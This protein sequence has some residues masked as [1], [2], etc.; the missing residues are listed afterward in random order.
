MRTTTTAHEL[1]APLGSVHAGRLVFTRGVSNLTIVV[2]ASMDELYRARFD[3]MMPEVG[4]HGGTVTVRY[5]PSLLPSR[6][7]ITLSGRVPWNITGRW[8]M[9]HVV[10][11]LEDLD[12][13][14][15]VISGGCSH[16][17]VRLPRPRRWVGVRI[18]G[19][20]HDVELV[21]PAGVPV[22]VRIGGGSSKLAIDDFRL[23]A[24]GGKTD[25]R[26]PDYDLIEARYDV[27]IGAG[28]SE[29]T[30]RT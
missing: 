18:G 27:E 29:V 7:E 9:S 15:L 14:G 8:G 30:V 24:G 4:V 16:T 19:G 1:T 22:R 3:G 23:R 28:A 25:W 5:R 2:D 11:D 20:A 10:A 21:R 6:G 17:A 13:G 26:S 12:L